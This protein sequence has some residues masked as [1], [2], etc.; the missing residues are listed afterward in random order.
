M[1]INLP[2][3]I[4]QREDATA[5]TLQFHMSLQHN[6]QLKNMAKDA[7]TKDT[8]INLIFILDSNHIQRT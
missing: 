5:H 8:Y 6:T 3:C 1:K 7:V 4:F 2:T